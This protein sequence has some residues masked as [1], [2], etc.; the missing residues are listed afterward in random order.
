MFVSICTPTYNRRPFFP[1]IIECVRRQ[2][3]TNYEWVIVDDGTDSVEDLVAHLPFV[4]YVR[5]PEKVPLGEKRN[6]MHAHSKGDI[7]VYMDDDDFYPATRVEHAVQQLVANPGCLVAGSSAMHIYFHHIQ[8]IVLF[9]PYGKWHATAGTFAFRKEL[10]AVAGYDNAATTG[11]EKAFLKN[12]TTPLVQLDPMHTILV[13]AHDY[14]TFDKRTLLDNPEKTIMQYT[15]LKINDFV[16]D[17]AQAHFYVTL[18]DQLARF[19][20]RN[21]VTVN[22]RKLKGNE[23]STFLLQQQSYI[24]H[25]EEKIK[26]LKKKET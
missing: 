14:N 20:S 7:L 25:L 9:G 3:Y 10:L 6:V 5:L 8:K 16:K 23:I 18:Q 26:L 4:K 22:G 21:T 12:Y 19:D 24:K 1:G 15:T 17:A 2:T 11:E 13:F